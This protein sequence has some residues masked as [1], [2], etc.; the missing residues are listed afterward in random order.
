[1]SAIVAQFLQS[2]Y[3]LEGTIWH[4]EEELLPVIVNA[5]PIFA[6]FWSWNKNYI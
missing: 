5:S 6:T 1:M 3:G 2:M 4:T